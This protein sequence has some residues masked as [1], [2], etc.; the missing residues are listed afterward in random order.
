MDQDDEDLA[1]PQVIAPQVEH[2]Q[3]DL[4]DIKFAY[5]TEFIVRGKD[6]THSKLKEKIINMGDS[7]VYVAD[8]DMI[9]V[10]I[11]TNN[12]GKVM[13]YALEDGELLKIKIENMKEQ[14][15]EI[16]NQKPKTPETMKNMDL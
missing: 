2:A 3:P 15:S 11:H 5:C 14:H 16:V 1:A 8:D 6:L 7:M 10:H 13:E 12:P 9:K 4:A